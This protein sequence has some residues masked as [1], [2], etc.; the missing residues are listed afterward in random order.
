MESVIIVHFGDFCCP[1]HT[2]EIWC[3][4]FHNTPF[5]SFM[6]HLSE[7]Q[8]C[9]GQSWGRMKT[10]SNPPKSGLLLNV[11]RHYCGHSGSLQTC[12]GGFCSRVSCQTKWTKQLTKYDRRVG[13]SFTPSQISK[14]KEQKMILS[15]F[16]WVLLCILASVTPKSRSETYGAWEQKT[17]R[18]PWFCDTCKINLFCFHQ[19]LM[20][21]PVAKPLRTRSHVA[22]LVAHCIGGLFLTEVMSNWTITRCVKWSLLRSH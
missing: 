14:F 19:P 9:R 22:C 21:V 3:Q 15:N 8:I 12:S 5:V 11:L 6:K 17:P 20:H 4:P 1:F 7:A 13:F 16:K 10:N 2:Q 18:K